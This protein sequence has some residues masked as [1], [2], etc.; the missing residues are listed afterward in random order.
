MFVAHDILLLYPCCLQ[1]KSRLKTVVPLIS[2]N[3]SKCCVSCIVMTFSRTLDIV[4]RS[5][6]GLKDDISVLAPEPLYIGTIFAVFQASGNIPVSKLKM[7]IRFNHGVKVL[8]N[9]LIAV[10]L[11]SSYDVELEFF[12]LL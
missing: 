3:L 5:A 4:G 9:F 1:E 12:R 10:V 7:M 6:T 8:L 11:I 2:L